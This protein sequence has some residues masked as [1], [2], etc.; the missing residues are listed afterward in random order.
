MKLLTRMAVS[1]TTV[2]LVAMAIPTVAHAQHYNQTNLVADAPTTA[3]AAHY[4]ANLKNAWGLARNP[5]SPWWVSD[6]G[7]GVST[8]YSGDG[9]A[10]A[11]VVKIPGPMGSTPDF[12]A[13]PT[14]IVFNGTSSFGGSHF[15]FVTED[16]T[17]SAWT[18]GT[19]AVLKVDNSKIPN[20]ASGAVY[21]GAT[22]A[23]HNGNLYLYVTNFRSGRVEIYDSN[24]Q[25]V[26]FTHKDNDFGESAFAGFL[27]NYLA[28]PF[29]DFRIPRGFAPFN[30]QNIGGS[31]FVTYARQDSAKHDDVAGDGSGYVDV[32]SPGGRLEMRLEH[33]PWLN[34]PWGAVWAPRDFGTFSNRVLIGNF[35]S[36]KIAVFD[37]FD[38]HFVG[39]MQ[40]ANSNPIVIDG[41]WAL[42]FGNSA[43]GCPSTPPAGSGLPK[44][45]SAGPYNALFFS[46]GPNEEADG[47]FGTLT[48]ATA[49]LSGDNQ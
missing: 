3:T 44:C 17:I 34:S 5:S 48:P 4:D 7:A 8:L 13:T 31:L 42:M 14:G 49:E 33:G 28:Q 9:T 32:F 1:L 24:F 35:G 23:E 36:G 43:V 22:I 18:G 11:L 29:E 26:K 16:G 30:I 41:L 38:G 40:D 6:N 21:K 25:P 20:P 47:L 45:G 27:D 19:A 2:A 39:F 46:A 15:I 37:G 12:T 10:S